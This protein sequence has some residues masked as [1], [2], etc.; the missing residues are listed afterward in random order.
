MVSIDFQKFFRE[1]LKEYYNED[2]F[3]IGQLS[4]VYYVNFKNKFFFSIFAIFFSTT[5]HLIN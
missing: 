3:A 4:S 1:S 2:S 5:T